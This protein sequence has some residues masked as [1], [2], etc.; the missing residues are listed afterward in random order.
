MSACAC[1]RCG[2]EWV[3]RKKDGLPVRCP[4]CQNPNWNRP[5]RRKVAGSSTVEHLAVN[6]AAVG[7][8]PTPP[9]IQEA[10]DAPENP[11]AFH[12]EQSPISPEND[13]LSLQKAKAE[14]LLRML[15]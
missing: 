2:Y 6:Q 10:R 12:V 14:Q 4:S 11:P 8:I 5:A 9:A 13:I 3:P 15:S 7:S 1:L